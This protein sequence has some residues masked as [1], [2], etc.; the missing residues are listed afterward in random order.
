MSML[1]V[2]DKRPRILLWN[3]LRL[4]L[5]RQTI[6]AGEVAIAASPAEFGL[7][8]LL[9]TRRTIPLSRDYIMMSVFGPDHGRD[10]RQADFMVARLRRMLTPFG[11]GAAIGT[12]AGRGYILAGDEDAV[13]PE[14]DCPALAIA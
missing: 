12:V 10:A 3:T 13:G 9:I 6:H 1:A 7:L 2:A 8:R 5:D 14:I 4:D 11:L